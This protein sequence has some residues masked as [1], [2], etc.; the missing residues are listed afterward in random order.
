MTGDKFAWDNAQGKVTV[1]H[2]WEYREVPLEEPYGQVAYL[3]FLLRKQ[4]PGAVQMYGIVADER[5]GQPDTRRMAI[6][7]ARRFHAFMNLS[8]PL[9]LDGGDAAKQFGDPRVTGAKLPLFVVIDRSGKV[10]HYHAG[11]YDVN[12]DRGL[13]E[14]D[15]VVRGALE[16]RE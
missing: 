9:L 1:L 7:G 15:G 11:F 8:Y 10:I 16:N 12:R 3:D 4:M 13:E 5:L 6:Q 14:L 2:F